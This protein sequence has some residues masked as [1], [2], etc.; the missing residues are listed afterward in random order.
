MMEL[1]FYCLIYH[2][3][4]LTYKLHNL[5]SSPNIIRMVTQA[6]NVA[7]MEVRSSYRILIGKPEDGDSKFLWKTGIYKSTLLYSPKD[8]HWKI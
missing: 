7:V 5:Y 1:F 6:K 8:Q 3:R 4:M 2:H